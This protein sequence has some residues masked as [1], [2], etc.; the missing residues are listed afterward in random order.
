MPKST[1]TV[2]EALPAIAIGAGLFFAVKAVKGLMPA[3]ADPNRA[4]TNS[5]PPVDA[6]GQKLVGEP[7]YVKIYKGQKVDAMKRFGVIGSQNN[8]VYPVTTMAYARD[9]VVGYW[10]REINRLCGLDQGAHAS[11]VLHLSDVRPVALT[12]ASLHPDMG[13][14]SLYGGIVSRAS[15]NAI[16]DDW[17]HIRPGLELNALHHYTFDSIQKDL[18]LDF[19]STFDFWDGIAKLAISVDV[20]RAVPDASGLAWESLYEA[21]QEAP[22]VLGDAIEKVTKEGAGALW[23]VLGAGVLNVLLSPVGLACAG[24]GLYLYRGE[25]AALYRGI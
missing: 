16:L 12:D 9:T 11:S 13:V 2:G 14:T 1:F 19:G 17:D 25:L 10:A 4:Q 7:D 23:R 5:G 3:E 15:A 22:G 8:I 18:V 24:A 20:D 6:P 21:A